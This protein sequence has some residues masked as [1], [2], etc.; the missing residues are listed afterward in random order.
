MPD[1][2]ASLRRVNCDVD[3][4]DWRHGRVGRSAG[5]VAGQVA[6]AIAGARRKGGPVGLLTHHLVHDPQAW[7]VLEGLVERLAQHPGAAFV[8]PF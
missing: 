4:I 3:I 6:A 2:G 7:S 8:R 5:D 1:Q